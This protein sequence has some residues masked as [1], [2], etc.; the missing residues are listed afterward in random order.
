MILESL[1]FSL[2]SLVIFSLLGFETGPHILRSF[3]PTLSGTYWFV[4]CYL[5]LYLI[6]GCLN[7]A[8]F[9]IDRRTH[10][11]ICAI[12]GFLFCFV[13]LLFGFLGHFC[14]IGSGIF[15]NNFVGA[16]YVY[17]LVAYIKLYGQRFCG[18]LKLNRLLFWASVYLLFALLYF[19]G[20]GGINDSRINYAMN[21][22]NTFLN[23]IILLFSV[24]LF[25]LFNAMRFRSRFVNYISSLSLLI[26]LTTE[27]TFLCRFIKPRLWE[28]LSKAFSYKYLL[29]VVLGVSL[30]AFIAGAL[31]SALY[32][33][34]IGRGVKR[35]A[36]RLGA[37]ISVK[38]KA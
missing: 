25:N 24:T 5:M 35:L 22:W 23:P 7:R 37:A 14:E 12:G 32:K 29:P 10:L 27:N 4:T 8:I 34:T 17:F 6:H 30:A 33:E 15:C 18:D 16:V 3:F 26:Y 9:A 20:L 31:I 11:W 28:L 38:S 36:A 1:F 13:N 19:T 2:L 21:A